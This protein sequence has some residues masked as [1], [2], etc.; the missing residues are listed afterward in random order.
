[1][2]CLEPAAWC[3]RGQYRHS[4]HWDRQYRHAVLSSSSHPDPF[5]KQ[6]QWFVDCGNV[7][8]IRFPVCGSTPSHLFLLDREGNIASTINE[9]TSRRFLQIGTLAILLLIP[10]ATSTQGMRKRLGIQR[11]NRLHK[12]AYLIAALVVLHYYLQVKS[13][14]SFPNRICDYSHRPA[15]KPRS[16]LEITQGRKE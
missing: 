7:W 14:Y 8:S 6:T 1:M 3:K 13:G 15:C 16:I 12:L 2:G 5:C 4:Y 10:L 9:V 11:W